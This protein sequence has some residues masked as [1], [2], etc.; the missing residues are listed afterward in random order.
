MTGIDNNVTTASSNICAQKNFRFHKEIW[1]I[2]T[3]A[4]FSKK[5]RLRDLFRVRLPL[6]SRQAATLLSNKGI[7]ARPNAHPVFRILLLF[8]IYMAVK[9]LTKSEAAATCG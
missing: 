7:S 4:V 6:R 8:P 1:L 2:Q 3:S 5:I 9:G